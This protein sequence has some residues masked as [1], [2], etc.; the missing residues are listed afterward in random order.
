LK[1]EEVFRLMEDVELMPAGIS[2]FPGGT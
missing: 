1:S 2:G